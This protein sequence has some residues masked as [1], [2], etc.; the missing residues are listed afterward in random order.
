MEHDNNLERAL[1]RWRQGIA[2][3]DEIRTLS[4]ELGNQHFAPGIPALM[5]LLDNEDEIV[6]YNAAM[7]L[8]FELHYEPAT[9]KLLSMLASDIDEDVRDVA[10]GSLRTLWQS[11]KDQR[12]VRALATA[13]LDDPDE[14]VRKSA[15]KALL[16]VN[17]VPSEEQLHLLTGGSLVVDRVRVQDIVN[18]MEP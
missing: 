10:A 5:Q 12:V 13:A 2:S 14:D 15:Y 8:G 3:L 7:A 1:D 11:T 18:A 4:Q 16:I 9:H 17:G 6:R